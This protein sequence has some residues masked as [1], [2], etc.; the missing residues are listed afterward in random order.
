MCLCVSKLLF[1]L[2]LRFLPHRFFPFFNSQYHIE[3]GLLKAVDDDVGAINIW[4]QFGRQG[5]LY[6]DRHIYPR[7]YPKSFRLKNWPESGYGRA[8][9][10]RVKKRSLK[11]PVAL[12]AVGTFQVETANDSFAGL[13]TQFQFDMLVRLFGA[14]RGGHF[15][16]GLRSCD[17]RLRFCRFFC[18][19]RIFKSLVETMRGVFS[20]IN[21]VVNVLVADGEPIVEG[22]A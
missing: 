13:T 9:V 3:G 12:L 6:P 19:C 20:Q 22:F 2:G 21:E 10:F 4:L 5:S 8:A 15:G 17:W 1:L 18:R 14:R 16:R 7:H 11:I